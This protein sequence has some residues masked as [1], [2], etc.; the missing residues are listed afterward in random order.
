[1]AK[2]YVILKSEERKLLESGGEVDRGGVRLVLDDRFSSLHNGDYRVSLD[3]KKF[4]KLINDS[5]LSVMC[6]ESE[7]NISYFSHFMP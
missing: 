7:I 1:M 6:G 5:Y 4:D 3:R 2:L